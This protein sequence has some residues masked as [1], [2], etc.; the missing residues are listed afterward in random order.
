MAAIK[1]LRI[2]LSSKPHGYESMDTTVKIAVTAPS[3]EDQV[4]I[5]AYGDGV[6]AFTARQKPLTGLEDR[7]V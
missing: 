4:N 5:F 3:I 7:R 1:H 6:H 2:L